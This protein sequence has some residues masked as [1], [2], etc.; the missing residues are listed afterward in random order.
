MSKEGEEEEAVEATGVVNNGLR[1]AFG[2]QFITKINC[3]GR[4]E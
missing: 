3:L 4:G 2:C 1:C